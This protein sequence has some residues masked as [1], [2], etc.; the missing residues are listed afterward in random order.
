VLPSSCHVCSY[1]DSTHLSI[2]VSFPTIYSLP[3]TVLTRLLTASLL[4][5]T[6]ILIH[7][8]LDIPVLT[9]TWRLIK[10]FLSEMGVEYFTLH[11]PPHGSIDE[12]SRSLIDQMA[13]RYCGQTVHLFG[14]SMVGRA[15]LHYFC[16]F[17]A[18]YRAEL[19]LETL[20]L[21]Q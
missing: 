12:W 8:Y 3:Q 2:W 9:G 1:V 20:P 4:L 11:I 19:M 17:H 13:S 7:G 21:G 5:F 6:V 16:H 10:R 15:L 18:T 14:Q